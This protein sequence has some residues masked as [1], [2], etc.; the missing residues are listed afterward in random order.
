MGFT[1]SLLHFLYLV[2]DSYCKTLACL[3]SH[4]NTNKCLKHESNIQTAVGFFLF[5]S[6]GQ[7][8]FDTD[9]PTALS[10]SHMEPE[11]VGLQHIF[12]NDSLNLFDF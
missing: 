12:I 3:F 5:F 9:F 1:V 11:R 10:S 8:D 4:W 6:A 2:S 7:D